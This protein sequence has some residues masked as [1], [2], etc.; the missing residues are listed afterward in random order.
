MNLKC[1]ND[2][3]MSM[4]K[5]LV[6]NLDNSYACVACSFLILYLHGKINVNSIPS[7]LSIIGSFFN[8]HL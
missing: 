2:F 3:F 5:I 7:S 8:I 4:P 1:L 6:A